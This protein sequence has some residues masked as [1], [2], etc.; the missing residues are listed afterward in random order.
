MNNLEE[1]EQLQMELQTCM[2]KLT[3]TKCVMT[4]ILNARKEATI[5]DCSFF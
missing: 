1:N 2:K 5:K 4:V 3:L